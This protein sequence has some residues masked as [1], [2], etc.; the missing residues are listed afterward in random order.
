[1]S[2]SSEEKKRQIT[3][4]FNDVAKTY[5]HSVLRFFPFCA[6]R[7]VSILK[8]NSSYKILDVATGTGVV[9]M[10]CAQ[11]VQGGG[12]V[13]G[14]DLSEGMLEQAGLTAKNW[15]WITSIYLPWMPNPWN[16]K[17]T[18]LMR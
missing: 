7:I 11:A 3:A 15:R 18:I 16:L 6:D 2:E 12:R 14:I 4:G 10:A 17:T 5:N 1:M 8:P 9:A 13:I